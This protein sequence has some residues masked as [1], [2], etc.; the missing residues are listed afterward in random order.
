MNPRDG[1]REMES[2]MHELKRELHAASAPAGWSAGNDLSAAAAAPATY[3][4][5][6]VAP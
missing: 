6:R 1:I 2:A 4:R 3:P 5:E